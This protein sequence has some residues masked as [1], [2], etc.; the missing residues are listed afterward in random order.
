MATSELVLGSSGG[1]R[2]PIKIASVTT[3]LND[4]IVDVLTALKTNAGSKLAQALNENWNTLYLRT[5]VYNTTLNTYVIHLFKLSTTVIPTNTTGNAIFTEV[6]MNTA[7]DR[8]VVQNIIIDL[9]SSNNH[10][11]TTSTITAS[12][13][14]I[15]SAT[16][17][18]TSFV[19]EWELYV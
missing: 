6:Y 19:G 11:F 12:G 3:N 14:T 7:G 4:N 8:S 5:Y 9:T 10:K 13:T 1:G 16:T 18:G 15:S 2:T 17:V